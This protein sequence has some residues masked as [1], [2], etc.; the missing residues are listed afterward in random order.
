[1]FTSRYRRK[2]YPRLLARFPLDEN[3]V[4]LNIHHLVAIWSKLRWGD[5]KDL[6]LDRRIGHELVMGYTNLPGLVRELRR[7]NTLINES[8]DAQLEQRN[9]N[10]TLTQTITL[11]LFL[12]DA[13]QTAIDIED[14]LR[15]IAGQLQLLHCHT[16]KDDGGYYARMSA[17]LL[18]DL[19]VLTTT[20]LNVE[21]D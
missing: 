16:R 13:D 15:Q 7:H 3:D 1:M 18:Q 11:D 17:Y 12:S 21:S 20:L 4:V 9:R 5:F 8:K 2:R 19:N 14:Y 10:P 6:P